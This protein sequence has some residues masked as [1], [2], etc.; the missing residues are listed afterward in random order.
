MFP[1]QRKIGLGLQQIHVSGLHVEHNRTYGVEKLELG[2]RYGGLGHVDAALAFGSPFKNKVGANAVFGR[3]RHVFRVVSRWQQI[4]MVA[5]D[6]QN[7]IRPQS[8]GND[9]RLGDGNAI[10]LRKY[11][12]VLVNRL[13]HRLLERHGLGL[14]SLGMSRARQTRNQQ[15]ALHHVR[16]LSHATADHHC[17]PGE[18]DADR[19]PP[20]AN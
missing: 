12:K 2:G 10:L 5:F 1:G 11:T 3:A 18:A 6:R 8:G 16:Q 15:S 14:I 4:Q 9:S 7:R 19:P 20:A 13:G 17:S